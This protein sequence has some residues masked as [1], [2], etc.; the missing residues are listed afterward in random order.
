[1]MSRRLRTPLFLL[2]GLAAACGDD[3]SGGTPDGGG[4]GPDGSTSGGACGDAPTI[5]LGS[6]VQRSVSVG[7]DS[8]P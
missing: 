8:R 2:L 5:A 4:G 7:G 1:M 6:W 3:S